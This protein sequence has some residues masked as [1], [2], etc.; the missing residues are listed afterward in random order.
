MQWP[1]GSETSNPGRS[2]AWIVEYSRDSHHE[3]NHTEGLKTVV[4]Q[5]CV[6]TM[7]N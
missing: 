5:N 3:N 7:H 1:S 4:S 2:R 6:Q